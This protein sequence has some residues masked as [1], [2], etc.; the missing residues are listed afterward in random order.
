MNGKGQWERK[1]E[2]DSSWWIYQWW[3]IRTEKKHILLFSFPK[4]KKQEQNLLNQLHMNKKFW[5]FENKTEDHLMW[6]SVKLFKIDW[7]A[8]SANRYPCHLLR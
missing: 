7:S 6:P 1:W 8:I 4:K 3:F 2:L 5:K